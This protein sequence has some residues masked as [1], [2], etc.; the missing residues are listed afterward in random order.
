MVQA[1]STYGFSY[2]LRH[3][4]SA[5]RRET[6]ERQTE[7]QTGK[8]ADAH[9]SLGAAVGRLSSTALDVRRLEAISISNN[10][11]ASR[12]EVTQASIGAVKASLETLTD[13][14]SAGVSTS[15]SKAVAADSARK[16]LAGFATALNGSINGEYTFAGINSS[17]PPFAD[18]T[19]MQA[20]AEIDAAFLA[21]F[22]FPKS[23]PAATAISSADFQTFLNSQVA[24]LFEGPSW[25]TSISS[26]SDEGI[27]ARIGF[28]ST[29]TVSVTANEPAIRGAFYVSAII[30]TFIDQ[31]LNQ[32]VLQ[33]VV[34]NSTE[35]SFAVLQQ[36]T[37]LSA[38]AGLMQSRVSDANERISR[39]SEVLEMAVSKQV[40]VD[41]YETG[42]R[43]NELINTLESTIVISQRI[44]NLS[45]VKLAR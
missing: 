40:A 25:G 33:D 41:P 20:V 26:A 5:L 31:P 1:T 11:A 22:G 24:P 45:F 4:I 18:E 7:L 32:G 28:G 36:L 14:V 6:T 17:E 15:Q 21:Y 30:A 43:L 10:L 34:R 38:T 19:G 44:Q 8:L 27:Q 39:L 3:A 42:I 37:D 2:S 23:D 13:A 9:L 35:K 16:A 29:S 12:L